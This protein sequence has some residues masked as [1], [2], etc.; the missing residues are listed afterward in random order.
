MRSDQTNRVYTAA[1]IGSTPSS[2]ATSNRMSPAGTSLFYGSVDPQTAVTEVSAHDPRPYVAVAAFELTRSATVLDLIDLP[3]R[4]DDLESDRVKFAWAISFI[5]SFARDLSRPVTLDGREH[6]EY[7]PTQ[8]LTEYF[9]HLSPLG[10]DG[11][12]FNSAQNHGI[13]YV[14]FIG[15]EGCTDSLADNST[16]LLR[17]LPNTLHVVDRL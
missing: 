10:V 3:A 15:P 2:R 4:I 16:A 8:V 7:V 5:R 12:R 17:L 11:I 14:L 6:L 1:S 13:N 9:R